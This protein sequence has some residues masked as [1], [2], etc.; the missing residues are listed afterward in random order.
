MKVR[1][2][3]AGCLTSLAFAAAACAGT[4]E[5]ITNGSFETPLVAA[6][7]FQQFPGSIPGWNGTAGIEIQSNGALGAGQ[8][9]PFG[10][11]YAELA[12]EVPSTYSQSVATVPG[13]D[14]ALSF[15]L[16][17]RPG[18]GSNSV[19]VSFTGNPDQTFTANDTGKVSF[20]QFT[21][22]FTANAAQSTLSFTPLNLAPTAGGGDLLDNVSLAAASNTGG[23]SG[24]GSTSVPS[25]DGFWA[26]L[27]GLIGV[28]M[29]LGTRSLRRRLV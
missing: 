4:S 7:Q 21:A 3:V 13:T 26:G 2:V 16:S 23:T 15:Y 27:T 5:L 22:T 11:Q 12:V 28:G 10:H 18:T 6:G 19:G 25:P 17:V 14:Y 24:S 9:T 29:L 1:H 20:Q 8:G